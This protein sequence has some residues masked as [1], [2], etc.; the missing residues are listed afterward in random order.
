M[1]LC[2]IQ[3]SNIRMPARNA[4]SRGTVLKAVSCMEVA[5]CTRLMTMPTTKPIAN[6]GAATQK[7]IIKASRMICTTE[8]GVICNNSLVEALHE[9]PDHQVPSVHQYEQH[10]LEWRRDH[11]RRQLHH[12]H[13]ERA[14]RDYEIDD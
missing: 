7:A 2:S 1:V 4:I 8:S 3:G 12:A 14:G 9:R 13:G 10:D 5:I 11:H 6:I